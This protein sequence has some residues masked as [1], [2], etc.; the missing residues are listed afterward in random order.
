MTQQ[1]H[2]QFAKEYLEEL[3]APFGTVKINRNVRGEV[4]QADVWFAPNVVSP[5]S[6]LGLLGR[7]ASTVCIFEP[8]DI[9]QGKPYRNA[10]SEVEI[11]SWF[12]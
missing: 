11:R 1:P 6:E 7:M 8:F 12:F 4:R 9:A 10:P 3:L 2:D 5:I